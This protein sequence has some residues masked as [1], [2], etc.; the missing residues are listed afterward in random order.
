MTTGWYR[1]TGRTRPD[2][3]QES[4]P[5]RWATL[6]T[7]H[8]L[9]RPGGPS[10]G[11]G[12]A[13][14]VCNAPIRRIR[15]L[16]D[17]AMSTLTW[18]QGSEMASTSARGA[19]TG[20]GGVLRPPHSPWERG[21]NGTLTATAGH[22]L[23][24]GA[25]ITSHQ[26]YP[27][28]IADEPGNHPRLP[29]PT[30]STHPTHCHHPLTPPSSFENGGASFVKLVAVMLWIIPCIVEAL[31]SRRGEGSCP[32]LGSALMSSDEVRSG[33]CLGCLG[34]SGSAWGCVGRVGF[35]PVAGV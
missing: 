32:R 5:A 7:R 28:A 33:W 11:A 30:R 31:I 24:K 27:G 15:A 1:G 18:D 34:R 8:A 25:S 4:G 23:P 35:S 9:P 19:I 10:P 6:V 3:R 26:P 12:R 29:H 16:P 2:H 13:G 20:A 17:G 21:T 22:Y 14:L